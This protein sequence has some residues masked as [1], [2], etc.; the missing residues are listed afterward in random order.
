MSMGSQCAMQHSPVRLF[1][2]GSNVPCQVGP[3]LV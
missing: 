3:N 1:T 2:N